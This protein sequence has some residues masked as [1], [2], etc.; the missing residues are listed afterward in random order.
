MKS[1][2]YTPYPTHFQRDLRYDHLHHLHSGRLSFLSGFLVH[3]V[4]THS[5]LV[6]EPFKVC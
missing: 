5:L 1:F 4:S 2:P 3:V 6:G